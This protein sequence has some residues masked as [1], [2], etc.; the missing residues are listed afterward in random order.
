VFLNKRRRKKGNLQNR[1]KKYLGFREFLNKT[2][3]CSL[4]KKRGKV[5]IEIER[6]RRYYTQ[7][8]E[9]RGARDGE[10]TVHLL[11]RRA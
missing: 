2:K 3:I 6:W 5:G 10:T 9:E 8:R 7:K 11:P 1:E 4:Q